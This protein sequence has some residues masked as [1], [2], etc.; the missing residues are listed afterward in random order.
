MQI[1]FEYHMYIYNTSYENIY[2]SHYVK[3]NH[4]KKSYRQTNDINVFKYLIHS[5]FLYVAQ[6]HDLLP[7]TQR[8]SQ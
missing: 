6:M 8:Q 2:N 1:Q 7:D 5:A 3:Q 4:G